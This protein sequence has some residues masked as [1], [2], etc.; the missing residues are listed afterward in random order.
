[1]KSQAIFINELLVSYDGNMQGTQGLC[2]FLCTGL[3]MKNGEVGGGRGLLHLARGIDKA[4][5]KASHDTE[6]LRIKQSLSI[7]G[8]QLL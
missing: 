7:G 1:M 8:R 3:Q 5:F 4:F 2:V 6:A